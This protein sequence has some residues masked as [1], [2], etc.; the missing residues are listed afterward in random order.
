MLE[1]LYRLPFAVLEAPN[2]KLK[3]PTWLQQPSAMKVFA[4]VLLSYF[5]VTGGELGVHSHL[6]SIF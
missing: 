3:K 1:A 5:L 6:V 2:L 4:M